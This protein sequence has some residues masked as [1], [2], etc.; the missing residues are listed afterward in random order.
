MNKNKVPL[1][2]FTVGVLAIVFVLVVIILFPSLQIT[3]VTKN[4][5]LAVL[6]FPWIIFIISQLFVRKK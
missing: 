1:Y 5:V 6:L 2:S 3:V 4:I